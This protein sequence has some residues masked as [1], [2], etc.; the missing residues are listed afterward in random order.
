MISC[1]AHILNI[2]FT[3]AG[4]A[5]RWPVMVMCAGWAAICVAL[6]ILG[7]TCLSKGQKAMMVSDHVAALFLGLALSAWADAMGASPLPEVPAGR[8]TIRCSLAM[9]SVTLSCRYCFQPKSEK[10]SYSPRNTSRK[11]L[12]SGGVCTSSR[13]S[14]HQRRYAGQSSSSASSA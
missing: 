3:A 1:I 2:A 4:L 12:I 7:I 6:A 10:S 14:R 13:M 5:L 9:P 11:R 8:S